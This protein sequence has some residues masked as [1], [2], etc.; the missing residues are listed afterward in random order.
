MAEILQNIKPTRMELLKL[1]KRVKLAD[2]GHE[3]LREKRDALISE[4]MLVIKQYRDARKRVEENLKTAFYNLLMVE[5][6]LGPRDLEQITGITL[7]DVGLEFVTKNIMGV[8]VPIL[9]I[10]D[11]VRRINE[12]GYGFLSTTAKL[13]DAAK[14]F[15]ESLLLI[16]KLAEVEESLR[17]IA[18]EVEKTRRR[19]N[20][21]EYIVIPRLNAT[22]KYIE[23]RMEEIEREG[24][25]RLKKIKASLE[26]R[27]TR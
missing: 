26:A 6:L 25:L 18:L 7:R 17:R 11:V 2:R 19:V 23:M 15:E 14:G 4:L 12:R 9:K 8:S 27:R 5:V 16:V 13:D 24:F 21:L 22:I 1:K 3:L 10:G 20:A